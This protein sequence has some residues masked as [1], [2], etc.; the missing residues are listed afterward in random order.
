[1][2]GSINIPFSSVSFSENVIE[3]VGA[4]CSLL[5]S[6][7]DKVVVVIGDEETDLER[8]RELIILFSY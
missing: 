4:H 6:K 2:I 3:N 7:G 5:K 1:M 8:V